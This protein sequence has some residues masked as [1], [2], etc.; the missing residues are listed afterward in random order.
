MLKKWLEIIF[1]HKISLRERMFRLVT[2]ISMIALVFILIL[3]RFTANLIILPASLI[4]MYI[5]AKISIRKECINAGATATVVLLLTLFPMVF[6]TGGGIYGGVP[7]WF[8]LCFIYISITLEGRR[9]AAFFVLCTLETLVCYY[10]AYFYPELVLPNTTAQAYF[11]SARSV[12]VAGFLTGVLLLFQNHL[13]EE[14]KKLTIQQKKEIEEL[15]QAENHFFSSM[16]HEIRTPINTI[17]GLNEMILR[18]DISED[19]AENARNIQ[20]ASKMLLTLINDILDLSKIKSGKMDIVN[21]SYET[22][23]LF[24]EIVNMIWIKAR[25]KGLEFKLQVDPSMP[26]MLCGDEVRI[27]QVLINLLNNA[28]KYT[29]EGS[30]TLSVRCERV[31]LNR[32]RVWYSVEDTGMGVKKEN[33]PYIFDAF[34][35]VDEKKNRHIE[36]T[37]LGLSIV[38]QLVELMG[39]EISVNSV[40]MNGST[41]LVTLEQDIMNEKE[42]GT[43]TLSSRVKVREGEHYRQSFEAPNAH[44]LVVDDNEMNLMVVS[45]LLSDTKIQIDTASSGAECLRLTQY[46]YYDCILM[47]HLM[48]EM[49]GIEC[50]HALHSQPGGLCRDV[51]VIA[52]TANAGSDNQLLYR[53]EGFSGYLAKPISGA[54]L[55]AAVLS[56]LPKELVNLS[57]DASQSEIGKDIL[58]FEQAKRMPLLVTTD[59]V[60]D[61]PESLKKEFGISVCP[62]Y[63]CTEQ[64]RFLDDSELLADELLAHMAEGKSGISQPPSVEDYERFFARK[65]TEAQDVIHITMAKHVS[66]GY[67]NAVEAAKSFE[68]VTVI[69]SGHLS[70]SM[71]LS[72]LYAAHMAENHAT[73]D[74]IVKTVKKLRR[75]ISSAFIIDSTHMMCKAGQIPRRVQIMCDALLLHPVI[76]LR[77]SRMSVGSME[78]GS[79]H[80]VI[81]GY[82]RK[83]LLNARNIDRRILFITYA[84]MDEKSLTYIQELVRQYCPFE[85]VYLQK[86]S[87]AIAS[88]CGPGSF[89][90]LFM[91]KNDVAISYSAASR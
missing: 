59:S 44:L 3:G 21:V 17:I 8:V 36:G 91:K 62:Y 18:G 49:D 80:H 52:L 14:E 56:I 15:N 81:R 22:G 82:I 69:D 26:S 75:Y 28:V 77:N 87:S 13:Y 16:S 50:L 48:P 24:S 68:N 4:Y 54:L 11:D 23:E 55:E 35:R 12:I 85:R 38:K 89:G 34:R 78:M 20:G 33:I 72:V 5:V 57:E 32:V 39:G 9:K 53:K 88:N 76:V 74:E 47:D 7:E 40:Y 27:K 37:G 86:A 66:E 30:V 19:V 29:K 67:R 90:L 65:L 2:G 41:F 43:F 60:C 73:R 45:K 51:P 1:D 6:F 84:G 71:G 46:Q 31:G 83:V 63:V 42:L 58:I 79:F 61:L 64:G 25:E 10:I 70:S